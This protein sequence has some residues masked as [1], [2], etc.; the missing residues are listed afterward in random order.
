[1]PTDPKKIEHIFIVMMENRSFD[2]LLGHLDLPPHN[3]TDITGIKDA[4]SKS[5]A[6]LHN[7]TKFAPQ[8]RTDPIMP[9]DPLH[10]REPIAQQMQWQPG[11][12][13]MSGFVEDYANVSPNDPFP[14]GQY[15]TASQVP[16]LSFL[17]ENFCV[18]DHWYACLPA[19]TQPNRLMAMSGYAMRD[20]TLNQQLQ[21]QDNLV[22]D[23]LDQHG[24]SWRVYSEGPPFFMLMPKVRNRIIADIWSHHFRGFQMLIHDLRNSDELPQVIFIEPEYTD[25]PNPEKG[26]DDHPTTSITRGQKFLLDVYSAISQSDPVATE[27]WSKSMLIITYDEHG[28]FFDHVAPRPLLTRQS[29]GENY[30]LFTTTGIRVPALVVSQFV[31]PG[32]AF[33]GILD[34]TSILKLLAERYGKPGEQYSDDVA[35]RTSIQSLSVVLSGD[36]ARPGPPPALTVTLDPTPDAAPPAGTMLSPNQLAFRNSL[37]EMRQ[38]DAK[39]GAQKYPQLSSYF[40]RGHR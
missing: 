19:S 40:L 34:H 12:P 36:T 39:A 4:Q 16:V 1:V 27:R 9:V 13:L 28:G 38:I 17:A 24:V 18:C 10:E 7:G 35:A 30:K 11:D 33:N 25:G 22:Y 29:H 5:Y 6:N 37:E 21:D 20:H 3:R 8:A 32:R 14:V 23:W 26:D 31:E 15:Y 2:H